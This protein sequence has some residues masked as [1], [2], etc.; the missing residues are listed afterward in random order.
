MLI[1]ERK[2]KAIMLINSH[3]EQ[4][5]RFHDSTSVDRYD[6]AVQL[7]ELTGLITEKERKQFDSIVDDILYI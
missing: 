3:I 5:K 7:A 2:Q 4:I 1:K 6:G